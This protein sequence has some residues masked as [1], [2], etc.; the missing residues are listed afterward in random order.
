MPPQSEV[1][2]MFMKTAMMFIA[3]TM[4][5]STSY[6]KDLGFAAVKITAKKGPAKETMNC[7]ERSCCARNEKQTTV[8]KSAV[9]Q[10]DP[11]AEERFRMKYGR[12][13]PAEESRREAVRIAANEGRTAHV[14]SC[15]KHGCCTS[16]KEAVIVAKSEATAGD[17]G[18]EARFRMK[19][20]RS[21]P[22][23][24]SRFAAAK[25]ATREPLMV[26]SANMCEGDCC[27]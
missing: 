6:G 3:G 9:T 22:A 25:R 1:Q 27:N 14:L 24:E 20:G 13:T 7:G 12:Y 2:E 21:S 5:L 11:A 17:P 4:L 16:Q 26:A 8:A 15:V 10:G 23:Q 19:Y 18:A